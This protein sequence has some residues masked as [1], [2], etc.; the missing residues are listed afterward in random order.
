LLKE[1]LLNLIEVDMTTTSDQKKQHVK[2]KNKALTIINLSVIDKI[3]PY[4]QHL[5]DPKKI[6]IT[7]SNLYE[8][9]TASHRL[10]IRS[11]LTNLKME[12]DTPMKL[13]LE[14]VTNLLNQLA[15]LGEKI[16]DDVVVEM[17][18]NALPKSQ[19]YYVQSILS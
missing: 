2:K 14:F 18:L 4:F 7:L 6:W 9:K 11:K 15:D 13:F 12:V 10:L 16:V 8:V 1:D 3:M 17:V 5:D 19:E